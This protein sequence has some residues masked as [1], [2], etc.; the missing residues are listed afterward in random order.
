MLRERTD[1]RNLLLSELVSGQTTQEVKPQTDIPSAKLESP[2]QLA[3]GCLGS[4][5]IQIFKFKL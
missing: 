4:L 2:T 3:W 5:T 1:A